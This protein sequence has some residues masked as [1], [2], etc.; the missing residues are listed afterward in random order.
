MENRQTNNR[1]LRNKR[2]VPRMSYGTDVTVPYW[3][4][5]NKTEDKRLPVSAGN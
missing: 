5:S 3:E 1:G 2:Q 4:R